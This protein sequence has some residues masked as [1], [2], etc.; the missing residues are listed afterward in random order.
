VVT[1]D[2]VK[3]VYDGPLSDMGAVDLGTW[4]GDAK[5]DFT[6]MV[7]FVEGAGNEYQGAT[8]TLDFT[9][10]ATQSTD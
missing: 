1:D 7:T 8:S 4:P 10:D 5:H 6:F 9:W 3:S 2:N